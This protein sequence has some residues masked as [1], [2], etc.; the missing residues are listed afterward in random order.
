MDIAITGISVLIQLV[1][2]F[3]LEITRYTIKS[4]MLMIIVSDFNLE[5]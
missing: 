1:Y 5:F 2:N 3:K 4:V